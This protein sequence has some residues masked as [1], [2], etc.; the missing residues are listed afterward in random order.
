MKRSLKTVVK[1]SLIVA[2]SL[3]GLVLLLAL[4]NVAMTARERATYKAPGTLITLDGR[5]LHL[6]TQGTTGKNIVFL[7][8]LGTPSPYYDF[9]LLANTLKD[10]YRVTIVEP[11]GYGW[12]DTTKKARTNANMVEDTRAALKAAGIDPPYI[13]IP[14]SISGLYALH[15][16]NAY[17]NE[18]E[19]VVCL[20]TSVPSQTRFYEKPSSPSLDYGL[21]RRLGLM[22]VAMTFFPGL[23]PKEMTLPSKEE[24]KKIL[25]FCNWNMDNSSV[26]DELKH[27]KGNLI[28][29]QGEK[30]PDS[31]PVQMFLSEQ[32][33]AGIR[34]GFKDFSWEDEHR[35]LL[36]ANPKSGLHILPGPHYIHHNN[37]AI[38]AGIIKSTF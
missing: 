14:H 18:I 25:M 13:L 19:G 10:K 35:A 26:I 7:P 23:Y 8:G 24:T 16:A 20:D 17:P 6:Y 37:Y 31:V 1:V 38:I 3:T 27:I 5:K 4:L 9:S 32:T 28:A 33:I 29:L 2:I 11:F 36:S 21:L 15:Y 34:K 30:F 22:R 12:S